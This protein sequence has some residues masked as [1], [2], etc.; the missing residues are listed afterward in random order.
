M[1]KQKNTFFRKIKVRIMYGCDL[2][3]AQS[4]RPTEMKMKRITLRLR[5]FNKP[6]ILELALEV[7]TN[8][9]CV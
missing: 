5:C 2:F 8:I 1:K 7:N 9:K 6:K 3:Y 4:H